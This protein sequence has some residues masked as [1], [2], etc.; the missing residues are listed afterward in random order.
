MPKKPLKIAIGQMNPTVGDYAGNTAK[1]LNWIGKAE[2]QGADLI[3]FPECALCGYPVWDLANKRA[4][5]E[6]GLRQLKRIAATTRGKKI[7]VVLGFIDRLSGPQSQISDSYNAAAWI[8]AGKVR[9]VYH[10]RLLPAGDV[11]LGEVFFHPGRKPCVI[12]FRGHKIGLTICEDIRDSVCKVKPLADLKSLGANLVINISASPYYRGV[13]RKRE[14]LLLSQV[15]KYKFPILY[16]NQ[17]GGQDELVFDGVSLMTDERGRILFRAPAFSEDLFFLF[18][19]EPDSTRV[20]SRTVPSHDGAEAYIPEMYQ[21][22]VTGVRDYFR[23][24]GFKKA[25][26]G[27]SGGIDSAIVA[28]IAADALGAH[29]VKGVTMPGPFSSRGSWKDSEELAKNIGIDFET[30]PIQKMY[31][32]FLNQTARGTKNGKCN[33]S[34]AM[35]N[36]QARLRGLELMYSSNSEG[37]LLLATGNKSEFA[38]GYC[39]LY[40]D[41]AGGLAVIG[42]VYK[43]DVYKL[44]RYRN[45]IRHLIP[46]A[47]LDK[48]P[49]AELR[50]NQRDQDSLP[51]YE[52]L[53]EILRL[54]IEKNLDCREVIRRLG[55]KKVR[56][57]VIRETLRKVDHNE[58]KRRQTPPILRVTEKAWFGRRMPLTNR[59]PG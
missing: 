56:S 16:V 26:L 10:K 57:G 52:V 33:Q 24:N 35:E 30:R 40:G 9:K 43:T 51:P 38:M 41:M 2:R 31:R 20:E 39:T 49:S 44:S 58:Y 25:I 7:A 19:R 29:A 37:R 32:T 3:V 55:K 45:S 1:I 23:K 42:D 47:I 53:D 18:P 22:L 5:V 46:D 14:A 27:L 21:A 34:P 48:A 8:E 4:F 59:F 28:C 36:L 54:Y 11:F 50:P 12:S 6:E 17:A 13:S 15:R